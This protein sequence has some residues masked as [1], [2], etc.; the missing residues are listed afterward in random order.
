[1]KEEDQMKRNKQAHSNIEENSSSS[2]LLSLSKEMTSIGSVDG[3]YIG[4]FHLL[5]RASKFAPKEEEVPFLLKHILKVYF[6][7]MLQLGYTWAVAWYMYLQ[8]DVLLKILTV[9]FSVHGFVFIVVSLLLIFLLWIAQGI[10]SL[11]LGLVSIISF[12]T[13]MG[14]P[15]GLVTI[16]YDKNLIFEAFVLTLIIFAS[17][18]LFGILTKNNLT[19]W[20]MPLFGGLFAIIIL[21]FFQY[22]YQNSLLNMLILLADVVVFTLYVAYDNQMIKIRF[23]DKLRDDIADSKKSWWL[24]A[25][26]SSIDI[27]LDFV[28]LF[29]DVL[30]LLGDDDD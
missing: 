23:L 10:N 1:M 16:V 9:L 7:F 18:S 14:I 2:D 22:Y 5:L 25:M 20:G 17:S 21:G 24:L 8:P 30:S 13:L 19:G 4:K 6:I 12:T 29:L 26:S 15:L 11:A 3:N 28:N 27:Y